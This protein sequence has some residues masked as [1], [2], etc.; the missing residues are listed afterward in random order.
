M[1]SK[2]LLTTVLRN[3]Q[4]ARRNRGYCPTTYMI[5]DAITACRESAKNNEVWQRDTDGDS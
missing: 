1:N 5:L 4:C 3:F 2:S